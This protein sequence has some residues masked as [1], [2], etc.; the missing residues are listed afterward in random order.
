[1]P[2]ALLQIDLHLPHA[3]SLKDKRMAIR[4]VKDRL[5]KR[6][7]VSV[8]ETAHQDLWQRA[9]IGIASVGPDARYLED[10]LSLALQEV[11]RTLPDCAVN[12]TIQLL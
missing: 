1:M 4:S 10:Q 11:E 9:G 2:V 6:F 8:S 5:R 3:H 12:G 7:N